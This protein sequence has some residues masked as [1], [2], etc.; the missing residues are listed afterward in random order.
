[1]MPAYAR[2]IAAAAMLVASLCT[3][4]AEA[5]A[6]EPTQAE[7]N[8]LLISSSST[9]TTT[10]VG[11]VVLTVVLTRKKS[12]L[13]RYLRDNAVAIREDLGRGSG[14]TFRD[15]AQV[16]GVA[17][18]DLPTFSRMLREHRRQVLDLVDPRTLDLRHTELFAE[19]VVREG[20]AHD[21]FGPT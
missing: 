2:S 8:A 11:G 9:T 16:F 1:M 15:I 14:A 6:Q 7:A 20:A 5:A 12:D 19:L 10:I 17:D 3:M 18:D 13:Q 4:V 21:L